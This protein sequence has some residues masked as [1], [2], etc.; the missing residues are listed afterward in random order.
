M[1]PPTD[2]GEETRRRIL[3]V[4]AQHLLE[5]GY[6]GTSLN[7]LIKETG[8][9]KGGFYFHFASKA[10]LAVATIA[11]IKEQYR[12]E[13]LR[14]AG[15][16][17]RAVEQIAAM[18]RAIA[19]NKEH[20]ASS[21]EMGRVCMELA[22]VPGTDDQ[23]KPFA[24]WFQIVAELFRRAQGEGDMDPAVN[25]DSAAHFAVT[26]YLGMDHVAEVDGDPT[27]PLRHVEDYLAYTFTA[28]GMRVPVPDT[29]PPV[30][31]A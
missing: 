6:N 12:D 24:S 19:L 31:A 3:E 8:L 15:T 29:R 11:M 17:D 5:R 4:A 10:D 1:T 16:H 2:K 26:A 27:L 7:E 23:I 21:A 9:T 14:A 13:V 25:A 28:V 20:H 30:G 22:G 18:V